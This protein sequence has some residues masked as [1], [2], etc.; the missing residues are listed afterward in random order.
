MFYTIQELVEQAEQKHNGNVSQ[1]MIETEIELTG[2]T[3]D[4]ILT[5]M[6][7]NLEV[8]KSSVVNGLTSDKSI[9]GLTGGDALKMDNY[10]K[11]RESQTI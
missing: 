6:S 8:L 5:I 3:K 11:Q 2:R 7:K 10:R 9:S 4:E 1:L